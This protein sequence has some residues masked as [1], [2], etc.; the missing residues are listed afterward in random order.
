MGPGVCRSR[1]SCSGRYGSFKVID[2]GPGIEGTILNKIFDPFFTTKTVG[3]GTGLG[4]S[5]VAGIVKEWGGS[6]DVESRPGRTVFTVHVP[7][8]VARRQAA[9]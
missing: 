1:F 7:L 5:V 8:A 9:E 4:L 2:D 3:S 6:I